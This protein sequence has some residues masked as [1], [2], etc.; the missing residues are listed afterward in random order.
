[1]K[2]FLYRSYTASPLRKAIV[3]GEI[4]VHT[5]RRMDA[6][7]RLTEPLYDEAMSLLHHHGGFRCLPVAGSVA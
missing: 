5:G 7:N 4:P 2:L 6:I 1:M 3:R